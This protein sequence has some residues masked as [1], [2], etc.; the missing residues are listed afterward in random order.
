M[1][2]YFIF[3]FVA[4]ILVLFAEIT[5]EKGFDNL[6]IKREASKKTLVEGEE[7][8]VTVIVEN[9]KRLPVSFLLVKESIPK[10]MEL[11]IEGEGSQSF[12][13]DYHIGKFNVL[14]YE[15]VKRSY[16]LKA[17]KRGTY[18]LKDM[19]ATVGDI[20]GFYTKDK[21]YD[22]YIELL[23]YP[24]LLSFDNMEFNTTSLYGDN[25][26]KRWIYKDPLYIKGIR[27]YSVE[28]RMKDIHWKSSLKMNK[29]MVKEYDFTSEMEF[30]IILNVQCGDP[31]WY[32]IN[33]DATEK[34]VRL[35]A[36]IAQK[37][38]AEG[39]PTGMWT[40]AQ[41]LGYS[42]NFKDEVSPSI[43][44]FKDILELCARVDFSPRIK[45]EEYLISKRKNF[46]RNCTYIIVTPYLNEDS[47]NVISKLKRSGVLMKIIDISDTGDI[48][49]INGIEKIVFKGIK[50]N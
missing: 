36:S 43:N 15:R 22:D 5:R 48:P 45:F 37:A 11:C 17:K 13:N 16:L 10:N 8:K 29:L 44:S 28:D 3:I 18:L 12:E 27:E 42:G 50:R 2:G 41:I 33:D 7:L 1:T 6:S 32:Y 34:G 26:I 47:I 31:Y 4:L 23:V 35:A 19:D 20:M 14:W 9:N 25:I 30:V 38:I 24:R 39:M 40:N 46:N 49:A 21:A